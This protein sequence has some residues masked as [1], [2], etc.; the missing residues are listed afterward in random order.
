MWMRCTLTHTEAFVSVFG[1]SC[2]DVRDRYN[3]APAQYAPIFV[4]EGGAI[5][6]ITARWIWFCHGKKMMNVANGWQRPVQRRLLISL[7][8][9]ILCNTHAVLYQFPGFMRGRGSTA[10][11]L[12]FSFT[13]PFRPLFE[14]AGLW[15]WW[16]DPES[17][18]P[19]ATFTLITCPSDGL[20]ARVHN[21]VPVILD[22]EDVTLWLAG[23]Y[24]PDVLLPY[25]DVRMVMVQVL[26]A[27]N[28][29]GHEDPDGIQEVGESGWW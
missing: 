5:A 14:M 3:I 25:P 21:R 27:I 28:N 23:P 6:C 7:P 13:I 11:P 15:D 1:I 24:V 9:L 29:P 8:L 4:A 16:T 22:E 2:G 10:S 12:Y 19:K 17:G 20:V 26:Q 18:I